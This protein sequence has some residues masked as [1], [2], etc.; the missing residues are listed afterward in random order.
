MDN[1]F[2]LSL[3]R[4]IVFKWPY[5]TTM[6]VSVLIIDVDLAINPFNS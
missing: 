2:A 6:A 1:T 5:P 4:V 3:I